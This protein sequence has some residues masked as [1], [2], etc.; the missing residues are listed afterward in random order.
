MGAS[1]TLPTSAGQTAL[2]IAREKGHVE[3]Q[4][5]LEPVVRNGVPD[6][7]LAALDRHLAALIEDRIRPQ[8][9]IRLRPLTTVILTEREPG[10]GIWF[11]IPGMYGGFVVRLVSRVVSLFLVR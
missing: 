4:P 2:D 8:L 3:L 1:R 11:P 9:T 10:A 6:H 7:I 5:S